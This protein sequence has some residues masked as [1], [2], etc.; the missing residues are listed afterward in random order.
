[1]VTTRDTGTNAPGFIVFNTLIPQDHPMSSRR[2]SLPPQY[3]DRDHL[4]FVDRDRP[5]G[6]LN[7]DEPIT[8]DPTQTILVIKLSKFG[9]RNIF[10]VVRINALI[11]H[12]CSTRTD[13][14]LPWDEWGRNAVIMEDRPPGSGLPIYVHGT[15]L[16]MVSTMPYR[17]G[18]TDCHRVRTF[19]FGRRRCGALPFWDEEGGGTER[20]A[21]FLDGSEFVF[22]AAGVRNMA[23]LGSVGSLGNGNFFQVSYLSIPQQRRRRLRLWQDIGG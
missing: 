9:Y 7:S 6:A 22:E 21:S 18:L 2:F 1:M 20:K 12:V 13:A 16:A 15:H 4:V 19:D 8:T 5:L 3:H 11:E 17:N 23:M 14:H 10:L